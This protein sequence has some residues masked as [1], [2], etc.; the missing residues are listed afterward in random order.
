MVNVNTVKFVLASKK[1]IEFYYT[2]Y[3]C[4]VEI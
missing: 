4:Y 2:P 3:L 1:Y